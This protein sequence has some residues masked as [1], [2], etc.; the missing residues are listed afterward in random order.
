MSLRACIEASF[1]TSGAI[2]RVASAFAASKALS[3]GD[4]EQAARTNVRETTPTELAVFRVMFSLLRRNSPR[5]RNLDRAVN[6]SVIGHWLAV[7]SI[8]Q[9]ARDALEQ[10]IFHAQPISVVSPSALL[11]ICWNI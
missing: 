7:F 1:C 8:T 4:F 3:T 11:P 2:R 6:V 5:T 9:L 10:A